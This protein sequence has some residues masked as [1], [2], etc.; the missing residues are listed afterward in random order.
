MSDNSG[1]PTDVSQSPECG[2]C[3]FSNANETMSAQNNND[4]V[5]GNTLLCQAAYSLA[6][7]AF[8]G[9]G[10]LCLCV[11]KAKINFR[12]ILGKVLKSCKFRDNYKYH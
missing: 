10:E 5:K 12:F 3:D 1:R 7:V 4:A 9:V 11:G 2:Q 6:L 8:L